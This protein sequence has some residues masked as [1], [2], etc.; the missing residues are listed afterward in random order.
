MGVLLNDQCS[1]SQWPMWLTL[2]S[3]IMPSKMEVASQL[4]GLLRQLRSIERFR[5]LK[6]KCR[7]G[8]DGIGW[9]SYTAVTPRASLQSDANKEPSMFHPTQNVKRTL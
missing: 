2:V 6:A 3:I 7:I 5:T 4:T 9:L 1:V 8:W